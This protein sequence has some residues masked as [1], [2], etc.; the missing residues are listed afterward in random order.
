MRARLTSQ[1]HQSAGDE[2]AMQL[3]NWSIVVN[4]DV[5]LC[6]VSCNLSRNLSGDYDLFY[7]TSF[8]WLLNRNIARQVARGMLMHCAMARKCI[9]AYCR[10]RCE[11]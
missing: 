5:A 10:K 1:E 6:N 3:Q 7:T 8:Y 2:A 11:K 9:A 4:R